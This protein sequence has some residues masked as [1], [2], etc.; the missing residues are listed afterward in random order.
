MGRPRVSIQKLGRSRRR[1]SDHAH[2]NTWQQT[3]ALVSRVARPNFGIC[4]DTFQISGTRPTSHCALAALSSTTVPP[5]ISAR[6][7]KPNGSYA[8][9]PGRGQRAL[10]LARRAH[11]HLLRPRRA[12]EDLLPPDLRRLAVR[13]VPAA[14]ALRPR[15]PRPPVSRTYVLITRHPQRRLAL[16]A[17]PRRGGLAERDDRPA[18]HPPALRL[19]RRL[20]PA[21]A[22]GLP[23]RRGGG[24][25]QGRLPA[26]ARRV[27]GRAADGLARAVVV[28]GAFVF[29]FSI[30]IVP[31]EGLRRCSSRRI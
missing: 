15:S 12:R 3:W 16:R 7:R 28:R 21:P 30:A 2:R 29:P 18:R 6:V 17:A 14:A 5:S 23:R 24:G 19:V 9:P 20:A 10:R 1:G 31:G 26:R 27:R 13:S 25:R 22:R 11:P 4:L 8:P